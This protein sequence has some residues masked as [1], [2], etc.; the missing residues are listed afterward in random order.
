M[1]RTILVVAAGAAI[2]ALIGWRGMCSGG[3]CPL[4]NNPWVGAI[5]GSLFAA[6]MLSGPRQPSLP[7]AN[8]DSAN[9]PESP[10]DAGEHPAR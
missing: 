6:L 10:P 4:S 9:A 8:P 1:L 5:L 2:G 3:T 7:P